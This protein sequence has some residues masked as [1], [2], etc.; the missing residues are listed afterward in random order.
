M[1]GS[2]QGNKQESQQIMLSILD[3]IM[4]FRDKNILYDN[5]TDGNSHFLTR[6]T[7]QIKMRATPIQETDM[8]FPKQ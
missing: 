4:F 7:L 5:Q 3:I 2:V 6:L 8:P 1:P